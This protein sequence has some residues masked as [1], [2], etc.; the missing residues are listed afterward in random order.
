MV[1]IILNIGNK[2]V[3]EQ[4]KDATDYQIIDDYA[5]LY[6]STDNQ[7]GFIKINNLISICIDK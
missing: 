7:I 1:K 3:Y 2:A 5:C 6:D 4:Y